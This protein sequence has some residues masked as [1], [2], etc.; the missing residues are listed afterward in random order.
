MNEFV[1]RSK[2]CEAEVDTRVVKPPPPPPAVTQN[3][4]Q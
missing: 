2:C 4:A 3:E 1:I